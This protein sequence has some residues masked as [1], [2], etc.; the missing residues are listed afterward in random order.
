MKALTTFF[1]TEYWPLL[2][3]NHLLL[4]T[5]FSL[6][7]NILRTELPSMVTVNATIFVCYSITEQAT[8]ARSRELRYS[9]NLQL[10]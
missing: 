1:S 10:Q 5:S 4:L 6:V 9:P 2:E 3:T 8:N 7:G